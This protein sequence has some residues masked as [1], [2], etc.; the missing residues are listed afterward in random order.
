MLGNPMLDPEVNN[1]LDLT[2]EWKT[3]S[4]FVVDVDVF[5]AYMQDFISSVIDTT[6][7]PRLPTSPGVR[8]FVNIDNA[9]KTGFEIS[10]SQKINQGIIPSI[11]YGIHLRAGS[12]TRRTTS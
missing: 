2:L 9:F 10:W 11:K 3:P 4:K 12:G 1:Q 8:Q 7:T 5:F 6:L